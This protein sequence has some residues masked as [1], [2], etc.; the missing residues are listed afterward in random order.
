MFFCT[1]EIALFSNFRALCKDEEIFSLSKESNARILLSGIE[2]GQFGDK[3]IEEHEHWDKFKNQIIYDHYDMN[4]GHCLTID[5]SHLSN[6]P[7]GKVQIESAA[8]SMLI[9]LDKISKKNRFN[10]KFNRLDHV[11]MQMYL[12]NGTDIY[13]FGENIPGLSLGNGMTKIGLKKT[14]IESL[15]TKADECITTGP[16][17][18]CIIGELL[19]YY[20]FNDNCTIP[21][22]DK[23]NSSGLISCTNDIVLSAIKKIKTFR[24]THEDFGPCKHTKPCSTVKYNVA[25][26]R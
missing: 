2:I 10:D 9:R 4:L 7:N 8:I 24:Y 12:H 22:L 21:F 23:K 1:F 15:P 6:N 16:Y 18:S 13:G 25:Q 17:S 5:V 11:T 20:Q 26:Q 19:K 3:P 14:I